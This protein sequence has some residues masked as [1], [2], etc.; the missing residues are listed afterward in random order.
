MSSLILGAWTA[1]VLAEDKSK[2]GT[3]IAAAR[4]GRR[5]RAGLIVRLLR[6]V[7][8]A[9]R[10]HARTDTGAVSDMP[11]SFYGKVCALSRPAAPEMGTPGR[12]WGREAPFLRALLCE[13]G[14]RPRD[15]RDVDNA[16]GWVR[17]D[18][19]AGG[20]GGG[21]EERRTGRAGQRCG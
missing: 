11:L 7:E 16:V 4:K 20:G 6:A 19:V 10:K 9:R 3:T 15:V 1:L 13:E 2:A 12:R 8:T 18:V 14:G 21:G 5:R 17:S